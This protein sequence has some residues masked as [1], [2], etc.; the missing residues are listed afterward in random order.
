[1]IP[2]SFEEDLGKVEVIYE[3][4]D[5]PFAWGRHLKNH[6]GDER[7]GEL[8]CQCRLVH[9]G[10]YFSHLWAV[11]TKENTQEESILAAI[12]KYGEVTRVHV[13]PKGGYQWTEYGGERFYSSEFNP[14]R[15]SDQNTESWRIDIHDPLVEWEGPTEA[16][17][18]LAKRNKRRKD[19][20]ERYKKRKLLN[21][22]TV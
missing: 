4:N 12:K 1:M 15:Y 3:E 17:K 14:L 10:D 11:I 19:A 9:L 18:A 20:R 5:I 8:R 21:K 16:M 13:G 2:A 6:L 7:F 22:E